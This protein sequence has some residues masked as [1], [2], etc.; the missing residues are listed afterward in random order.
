[1]PSC[2]RPQPYRSLSLWKLP[3]KL[4]IASKIPSALP[5]AVTSI[6][7]TAS[8]KMWLFATNQNIY[9]LLY[10]HHVFCTSHHWYNKYCLSRVTETIFQFLKICKNFLQL[11]DGKIRLQAVGAGDPKKVV[12]KTSFFVDWC[13]SLYS[14]DFFFA[15]EKDIF[16]LFFFLFLFCLSDARQTTFFVINLVLLFL[17]SLGVTARISYLYSITQE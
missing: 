9:F 5:T 17:M 14:N 2:L 11:T 13:Y 7:L 12:T 8:T 1:M 10:N 15:K 6:S 16:C 3:L 4:L